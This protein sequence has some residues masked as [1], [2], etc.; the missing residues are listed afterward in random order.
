MIPHDDSVAIRRKQAPNGVSPAERL[1]ADII[2][3][4]REPLLVLDAEFRVVRTNRAFFETF[5]VTASDTLGQSL[6]SLG[7]GQWD[8]QPLRA[9]LQDRLPVER[10]LFDVDVDHVFPAIGRRV[11]LLNARLVVH[12]GETPQMTLL[13]IED[14]TERRLATQQLMAKQ[15]ELRRSNAALNEFA[16]VAAHDLQEPLR[17]ILSFG[18]RLNTSAGAALD[19][20]GRKYLDRV[21]DGATRMRSLITD[22][23]TYSQ[24][25]ASTEP[26]A[27]TDL[28]AVA[29][30]VVA[31]LEPA[32]AENHGI[33][34]VG[35]LPTID[36]DAAQMRRLFQNLIGNALKFRRLGTPPVV[37]VR[38][39]VSGSECAI[40]VTDNGIGIKLEHR[41]KIF[42]LFERLHSRA[43]YPGA[44][45]GLAI[46]RRIVE[47]HGGS[48][49]VADTNG[50]GSKLTVTLPITRADSE[51]LA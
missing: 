14:V 40:T 9:L 44:G 31:D 12:D 42:R 43:E 29:R 38:G 21:L 17:K 45:I 18:E 35:A 7:D 5:H 2:D 20:T 1:L 50:Q 47:R 39:A 23:L 3:T 51:Q 48:I 28:A 27:A 30:D 34:D 26:F 10:E 22:L 49:E 11:M 13:A 41:E 24:A 33:V 36:A 25:A 32:I 6:F 15:L 8:I 37:Q 19:G 16:F 46:C 4:V